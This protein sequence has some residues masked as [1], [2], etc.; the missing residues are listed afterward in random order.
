MTESKKLNRG[1]V[2]LNVLLIVVFFVVNIRMTIIPE[3]PAGFQISSLIAVFALTAAFNYLI[4]KYEK[5]NAIYYKAYVA[6]LMF[7]ELVSLVGVSVEVNDV[8]QLTISALTFSFSVIMFAGRD[9]GKKFSLILCFAFIAVC[10]VEIVY[11]VAFAQKVLLE[12]AALDS[13]TIK[14]M[15]YGKLLSRLLFGMLLTI[16]TYGK[17]LDKAERGTN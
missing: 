11:G 7:T 4:G 17:Y 9:L 5:T 13:A 1:L 2:T 6:L 10:I 15:L 3:A 16:M 14:T 12:E 8:I